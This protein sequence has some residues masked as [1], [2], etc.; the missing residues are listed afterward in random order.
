M[1]RDK[2]SRYGTYVNGEQVTER[3]LV[4]GDRIR[5]GRSGGAE[6]VFLLADSA[7]AVDKAHHDR[8][9]RPAPDRRAPRGPARAR[10]RPRARRRAGA[11]ARFGDRGQRRRARVHHAGGADRR[12]RVQAG[13]RSRGRNTLPGGS[14]A[15]S[16]KIPE[17]V[18]RTGR[19]A[20]RRRPARRRSGERA[21]GHGGARH[22]QRALRAAAARALSRSGRSRR[23][24]SAASACSISTAARR[25]RC[26]RTPRAPRSKR[27]RPKRPSPSRTPGS[28]A[29]RWRRRGW[30]RRC[31][32]RPRSSRRCCRRPARVG[33][34][35]PRR[36]VVA[37]VPL[38]RRRLLRLRRPVRRVVRLRA[39]RRR[40]QGP[41]R[42]APERD[43]AGHVRG[44]GGRQR[45]AVATIGNVNLALYRRGIESRFVTLMYGSLA[46]ERPADLL[47]RRATTR[48]SSSAR[49]GFRRLECGGPIVG[50]F[51]SA[52]LRGGDGHARRRATG[53]SSSATAC[54]RRCR[55]PA[56]STARAA[57][58]RSCR[59]TSD[60]EP[61]KLLEALFADVREF[62]KGAA[63]SDDIT[64][65]GSALRDHD[66]ARAARADRRRPLAHRRASSSG[67]ASTI[68]SSRAAS[69]PTCF[70]RRAPSGAGSDRGST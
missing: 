14:F 61:Q 10:L 15:T 11:G 59:A 42:G 68:C 51:E 40:G 50:L 21:H 23:A 6:M 48:R 2:S 8:D 57:S 5:L 16:R 38:D 54:P 9:R 35:L 12:A 67:T 4:H 3:P 47:Q 18:F 70:S 55:P 43:D 62:A 32:S 33:R 24:R 29:R 26:S 7:P 49:T 30:S 34:L 66:R 45:L 17:E 25:A 22:P 37:A 27:S 31:G 65:H 1:I 19:A 39:R 13:A 41:A 53:S 69:R 52:T 60:V 36:G 64:A 63:Q 44:A 28:T 58:S 20:H 46:R 56:K